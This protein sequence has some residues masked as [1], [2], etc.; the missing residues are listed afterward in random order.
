MTP[1]RFWA[2]HAVIAALGGAL[3]L[4]LAGPLGRVLNGK[5]RDG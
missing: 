3:A 2:M 1:A 4:L 5:R